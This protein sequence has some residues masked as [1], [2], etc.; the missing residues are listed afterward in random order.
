VGV[1]VV[2]QVTACGWWLGDG[3]GHSHWGVVGKGAGGCGGW[4]EGGAWAVVI[5]RATLLT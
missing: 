5:V 3:G 1:E 4:V 2:G